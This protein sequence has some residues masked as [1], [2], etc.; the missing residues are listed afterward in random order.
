M[1]SS[2]RN[3]A[4]LFQLMMGTARVP[5]STIY[6]N[7]FPSLEWVRK[8]VVGPFSSAN[9]YRHACALNVRYLGPP[10]ERELPGQ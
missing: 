1:W 7:P 2:S 8:R 6:P 10:I 4:V 9:D 3:G 5:T